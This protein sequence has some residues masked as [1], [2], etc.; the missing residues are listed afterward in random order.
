M[1]PNEHFGP[2][3]HQHD[4]PQASIAEEALLLLD[5]YAPTTFDWCHAGPTS[6]WK[7][8]RGTDHRIDYVLCS[9]QAFEL[10]HS[11]HVLRDHDSGFSHEDHLPVSLTCR[12]WLQACAGRSKIRWD[13]A[14]MQD[15]VRCRQFQEAL[16]T[17]PVPQ[18]S[19]DVDT[20]AQIWES[21]LLQ[22]AQ[23]FFTSQTN[24]RS[25]PR[26]TEPT[27]NLIAI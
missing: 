9:K 1:A 5:F 2:H 25:R 13:F 6:T 15:P 21:N 8:P 3:G 14:A 22:L 23:Q 19:A 4:S 20:H 11:S 10:A 16:K 27:C 17:L 7:H 26:L 24:E 18:W 12:G